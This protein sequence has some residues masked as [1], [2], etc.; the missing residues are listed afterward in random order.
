MTN[1]HLL[2]STLNRVFSVLCIIFTYIGNAQSIIDQYHKIENSDVSYDTKTNTIEQW[3]ESQKNSIDSIQL[4][5]IY[6]S[7]SKLNYNNKDYKKA[8]IYGHKALEIQ[9]EYIDSIPELVN[10]TYNNLAYFYYYSG[11]E[12]NA[13]K[14][15]KKLIKQKHKDK[16]SIKAY[17]VGLANL[18]IERGDYY[19]LLDY[20][21]EA[22]HIIEKQNDTVLNKEMYSVYLS[23]SRVYFQTGKREN[24]QKAIEYLKKTENSIAHLSDN[25]RKKQKIIIY[26]RY[27]NIYDELK[28]NL[29]AISYYNKALSLILSLEKINGY[30][31]AVIYN[32]L[33]YIHA[34]TNQQETAYFHYQK[35][36]QYDPQHISIF[37]NLG[38]YYLQKK[39]YKKALV[40][41]QKA[42]N[43]SIDNDLEYDKVPSL[44]SLIPS[45][46]KIDLVNDLKDKANAWL[47]F[48]NET[49]NTTYLQH[50]LS[51]IIRA[52]QLIDIIRSESSEQRSKFFWRKKGVD[53][54]ILATSI[55]YTLN[56][57]KD[58]F[59]FMEKSKSLSLLENL[60]HEEA[61]NR[62]GLPDSLQ[63][64]EYA[65]KY[66][67]LLASQKPLKEGYFSESDRRS[68][69]FQRKRDYEEFLKS[70]EKEYPNYYSYKKEIDIV[71]FKESVQEVTKNNTALVQYILSDQEGYGMYI[72]S[73]KVSFFKIADISKLDKEIITLNTLLHRPLFSI[74]DQ[75][76]YKKTSFSI[77]SQLLP[78]ISDIK[79]KVNKKITIIPDHILQY[80]PFEVLTIHPSAKNIQDSYLINFIETSYQYSMS[81]SKSTDKTIRSSS[82]NIL[83]FA[84]INFENHQ[85]SDLKKSEDK[86]NEIKGLFDGDFFTEKNASKNNFINK[87]SDYKTIHLSTHASSMSN[88]EPWIAF[89][90]EKLTLNELYFIK[91]QAEL[92]ILDACRTGIGEL[93]PGEGI[94]SLTRGFFHSGAKSVI[95]SLWNTNEKSTNKIVLNFYKHLKK[96]LPKS[97]ALHQSKLEYLHNHQGSETSPYFWGPL[98][99]HGNTDTLLLSNNSQMN[100]WIYPF[101]FILLFFIIFFVKKKFF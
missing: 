41:Y 63:E 89:Y 90:D 43:Y 23:F 2:P 88:Q 30:R 80:I 47:Q 44:E 38:D 9:K 15:F 79:T 50:A 64:K 49:Q 101:L 8:I 42:I 11:D 92:V 27:G 14:T 94:M 76:I 34:R 35:G 59:Y 6:N 31:I 93:Q 28:E 68:L 67:I 4:S 83:G 65:L 82:Q 87:S 55:C 39:E 16:Y 13:I 37:D 10:K 91:Q 32:N 57:H 46:N 70:L 18:F 45:T 84:P 75:E 5:S 69:I 51:T 81:L 58:A 33:G 77:A 24:Y 61:K 74:E 40:H 3:I 36:L 85:L 72:T 71:S 17:T 52:D 56:K 12:T 26:N 99:L 53:L 1:N 60:T 54:Y 7:Y 22:E 66:K 48:Y 100:L 98:V 29:K 20:L 96:G 86:M 25:S 78:F 19:K 95:S 73:D 21:Q 62:G 97:S